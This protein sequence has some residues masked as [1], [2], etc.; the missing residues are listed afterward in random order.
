MVA[1]QV[2]YRGGS[3]RVPATEHEAEVEMES[4][5]LTTLGNEQAQF[6]AECFFATRNRHRQYLDGRYVNLESA[7]WLDKY[8]M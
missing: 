6:I 5:W 7:L 4:H 8:P 1:I 3:V 2:F